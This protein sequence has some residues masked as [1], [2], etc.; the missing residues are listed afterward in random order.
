MCEKINSSHFT[1]IRIFV[2][3][4]VKASLTFIPSISPLTVLLMHMKPLDCLWTS[5][6]SVRSSSV[7]IHFPKGQL[8]LLSFTGKNILN[9]YH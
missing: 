8:L 1:E 3:V 9:R 6:F 4:T 7:I 2:V 5:S